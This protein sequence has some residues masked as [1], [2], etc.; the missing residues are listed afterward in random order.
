MN[1]YGFYS[2][3]VQWT[4]SYLIDHVEI[5]KIDGTIAD[6][7]TDI[8]SFWTMFKGLVCYN[9]DLKR[10]RLKEFKETLSDMLFDVFDGI[11]MLKYF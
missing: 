7:I 9:I 4:N 11:K 6:E 5:V 1:R 10:I 3:L 2:N 8:A